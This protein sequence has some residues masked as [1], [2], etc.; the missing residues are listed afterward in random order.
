MSALMY[1]KQ[2]IRLPISSYLFDFQVTVLISTK[3][4]CFKNCSVLNFKNLIRLYYPTCF[5]TAL[6]VVLIN[7]CG[8]W[9]TCFEGATGSMFWVIAGIIFCCIPGCT[10]LCAKKNANSKESLT[11]D[12]ISKF[13]FP[14]ITRVNSSVSIPFN[15]VLFGGAA[16]DIFPF[17]RLL[18]GLFTGFGAG[19][20]AFS[21][22][23]L[24]RPG[25]AQI[26]TSIDWRPRTV[27]WCSSVKITY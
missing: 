27:P 26:L 7:G 6:R 1:I 2:S 22:P 4:K 17:P 18:N 8:V 19:N 15:F 12:K 23:L 3:K 14:L 24:S 11:F 9:N 20:I 21:S 5:L 10:T 13:S 25:Q 16:E